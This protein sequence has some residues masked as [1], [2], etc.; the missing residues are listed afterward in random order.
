MAKIPRGTCLSMGHSSN[1][2]KRDPYSSIRPISHHYVQLFEPYSYPWIPTIIRYD[3][4]CRPPWNSHWQ[5]A[6]FVSITIWYVLH[7]CPEITEKIR[8]ISSLWKNVPDLS[9]GEL[10]PEAE[11]R[12]ALLQWY[13]ATCVY[14]LSEM[15]RRK[16][17]SGHDGM[18]AYIKNLEQ[19]CL[20]LTRPA[21]KPS[22]DLYTIKDEQLDRLLLICNEVIQEPTSANT[23]NTRIDC[24]TNVRAK[25]E[26]RTP[27]TIIN[28]GFTGR[29]SNS[30]KEP[31]WELSCLNHHTAF[32]IAL[33]FADFTEVNDF[34]QACYD[35]RSTEFTFH[36]T[37][38]RSKR[39][40]SKQWWDVDA[41]AIVCATLLHPHIKEAGKT[42]HLVVAMQCHS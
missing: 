15:V 12:T 40:M 20:R 19:M 37:W 4:P 14:N 17:S 2:D 11:P 33:E 5:A 24:M 10:Q 16:S 38:D 39:H 6:C 26:R 42:K 25:I 9:V 30:S 41:S 1:S 34:K 18:S 31:P 13:H 21:K 32:R 8:P 22:I 23:S 3:S 28:P 7:N 27:T 29:K 36:P 35:F